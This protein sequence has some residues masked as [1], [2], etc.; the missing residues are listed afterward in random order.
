M[1]AANKTRVTRLL[2]SIAF[3]VRAHAATRSLGCRNCRSDDANSEKLRRKHRGEA[4]ASIHKGL[5][6]LSRTRLIRFLVSHCKEFRHTSTGETGKSVHKALKPKAFTEST[7][8]VNEADTN[9]LQPGAFFILIGGLSRRLRSEP[10]RRESHG[11]DRR[12]G[13]VSR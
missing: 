3:L 5:L 13:G 8:T 4:E 12:K 6:A 7:R 9:P 10:Q 11:G 1:A 2:M